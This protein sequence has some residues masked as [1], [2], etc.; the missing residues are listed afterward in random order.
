M[1]TVTLLSR[2]SLTV[3]V[4]VAD[5]PGSMKLGLALKALTTGGGSTCRC[6]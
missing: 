2:T 4:S 3:Q 1:V 5:C 6:G